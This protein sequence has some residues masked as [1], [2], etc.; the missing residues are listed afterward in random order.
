MRTIWLVSP[1]RCGVET[2]TIRRLPGSP[3]RQAR[4]AR[5]RT[6]RPMVRFSTTAGLTS[7]DAV[8]G[9]GGDATTAGTTSTDTRSARSPGRRAIGGPFT[10]RR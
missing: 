9:A 3:S 10:P 7:Y 1:G 2:S 5:P 4:I 8:A 6:D